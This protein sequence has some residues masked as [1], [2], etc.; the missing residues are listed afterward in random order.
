MRVRRNDQK[1]AI[2]TGSHARFV[3]PN[4][5]ESSLIDAETRASFLVTTA[6]ES[7]SCNDWCFLACACR[8]WNSYHHTLRQMQ[9]F[10]WMN[11]D[12]FRMGLERLREA[13]KGDTEIVFDG[14]L[15]YTDDKS[16]TTLHARC[17]VISAQ[18]AFMCVWSPAITRGHQLDASLRATLHASGEC[19]LVNLRSGKVVNVIVNERVFI[20]SEL[21]KPPER[22]THARI[23]MA[24]FQ[25][26]T[27]AGDASSCSPEPLCTPSSP[28]LVDD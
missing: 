14:R 12:K 1:E 8:A 13:L 24:R 26:L 9:P 6:K 5:P 28:V 4:V 15:H 21:V 10:D 20:L 16:Q 18:R 27:S 25:R 19:R 23:D 2:T 3:A 17:D 22:R 7:L 11:E